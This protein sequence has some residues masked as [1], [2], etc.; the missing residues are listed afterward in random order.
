MDKKLE[1]KKAETKTVHKKSKNIEENIREA[2]SDIDGEFK[3]EGPILTCRKEFNEGITQKLIINKWI[4][5]F[6]L[7]TLG[8]D[9]IINSTEEVD[10]QYNEE[11]IS[12]VSPEKGVQLIISGDKDKRSHIP[13]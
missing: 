2:C 13:K 6:H 8:T 5:E 3:Q 10:L 9:S 7:K 12:I 1:R 4:G 11:Q